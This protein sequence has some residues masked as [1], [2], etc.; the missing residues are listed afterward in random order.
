MHATNKGPG[1]PQSAMPQ[2]DVYVS[3]T[4]L[5]LRRFW[6]APVFWSHATRS[7]QQAK[8]APG[9]ISAS[10][11][12]INGVHHSV[13][14]WIDRSAMTAY[15]ASGAHLQAMR[16]LPRIATGK[17]YGFTTDRV[18]DWSEI[19]AMWQEHGRVV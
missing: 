17:T 4:G 8:A 9:N 3:I 15:L 14:V 2:S 1:M 19:P 6:H 7:L 13:S 12:T 18:P 5:R 10:A 16:L 11:R